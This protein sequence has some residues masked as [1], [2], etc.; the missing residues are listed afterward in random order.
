MNIALYADDTTLYS[1]CDRHLI[2]CNN[3]NWLLNFSLIYE[4]L[5]TGSR[6]FL[7][8]L[9]LGKFSWFQLIGLITVVLLTWK[10]MGLFLRTN[11]LLRCWGWPSLLNWIGALTWSLLLKLPSRKL[12]PEF[13][14]WSFFLLRLLCI[15]INP[16]YDH[17]W[18]TVNRSGLVPLVAT[19]N[20][21][22]SYKNESAG[23]LVL[24]LLLLLNPWLI[25]EM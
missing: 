9:K 6:K 5:W 14:L 11:H 24:H 8:I 25:V 15:S 13:F 17:L 21:W 7:L 18:N 3:L 20:C 16:P 22:T 10:W 23:L 12:E 2:C 4:T 19:W 1:K